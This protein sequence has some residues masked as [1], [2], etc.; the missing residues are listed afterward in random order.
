MVIVASELTI[1]LVCTIIFVLRDFCYFSKLIFK[2]RLFVVCKSHSAKVKAF[3]DD[4][5][6]LRLYAY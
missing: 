4:R 1:L 2:V 5:S 3:S 6:I